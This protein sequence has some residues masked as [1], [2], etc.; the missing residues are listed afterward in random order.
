MSAGERVDGSPLVVRV[1]DDPLCTRDLVVDV[2]D[3]GVCMD[4]DPCCT[5]DYGV[6]GSSLRVRVDADPMCT[7]GPSFWCTPRKSRSFF[8]YV[9]SCPDKRTV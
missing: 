8:Q 5:R 7:G 6:G 4:D 3:P 9:S 1:D 2:I